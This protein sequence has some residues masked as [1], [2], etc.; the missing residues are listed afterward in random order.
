MSNI[1]NFAIRHDS[2]FNTIHA[3]D[4]TAANLEIINGSFILNS[5][6]L[7][8]IEGNI[9]IDATGNIDINAVGG[10]VLF[11]ST[12]S[13]GTGG[14]IIIT[15]TEGGNSGG[16]IFITA[17][18]D[19]TGTGGNI[20]VTAQDNSG[21]GGNILVSLSDTAAVTPGSGTNLLINGT[22]TAPAGLNTI[23]QS[24]SALGGQAHFY[25]NAAATATV[26][27]IAGS[28]SFNI[29]GLL[30]SGNDH[31]GR[32]TIPAIGAVNIGSTITVTFAHAFA[33]PTTTFIVLQPGNEQAAQILTGDLPPATPFNGWMFIL[34]GTNTNFSARVNTASAS[35]STGN[36][37]I[38]YHVLATDN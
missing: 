36:A 27:Q 16:D 2:E 38:Y 37:I 1:I 17:I 30:L 18:D 9:D 25:I 29:P 5:A 32:I 15:A 8:I 28:L 19:V 22:S 10:H 26:P 33:A 13:A 24:S 34:A 6:D 20:S 3:N 4:I 23:I 14:D 35:G 31:V 7:I 11:R 21:T 12:G